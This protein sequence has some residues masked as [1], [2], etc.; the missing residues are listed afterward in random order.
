MKILE[1]LGGVACIALFVVMAYIYVFHIE[2]LPSGDF[3]LVWCE[4]DWLDQLITLF[5]S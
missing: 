2:I 4:G 5:R 3:R 1:I